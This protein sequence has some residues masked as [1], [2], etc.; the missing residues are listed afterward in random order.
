MSML[1]TRRSLQL[2]VSMG[3]GGHLAARTPRTAAAADA[4]MA[5]VQAWAMRQP[6]TALRQ[7]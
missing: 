6:D 1:T 7:A 2:S 4:T 5:M 3:W